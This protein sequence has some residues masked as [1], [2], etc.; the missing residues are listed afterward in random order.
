VEEGK[1]AYANLRLKNPLSVLYLPPSLPPSLPPLH[2]GY[3]VVL[4]PDILQEP[5]IG[6]QGRGKHH[7]IIH[8][9]QPVECVCPHGLEPV[10]VLVR[11]EGGRG[12][13][14]E[15]E[16]AGGGALNQVGIG[17]GG[18]EGRG[19]VEGGGGR[20]GGSSVWVWVVCCV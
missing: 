14:E 11:D 16:D 15:G 5:Q 13:G 3:R 2:L 6:E 9:L 20:K 8:F 19:A 1:N 12:G 17:E 7:A 18:R 10:A 4:R